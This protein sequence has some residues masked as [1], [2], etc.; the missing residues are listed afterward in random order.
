MINF[1]ITNVTVLLQIDFSIDN[2]L[3]MWYTVGTVKE[4]RK[5]Q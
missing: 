3:T 4:R 1:N 5:L 2:R